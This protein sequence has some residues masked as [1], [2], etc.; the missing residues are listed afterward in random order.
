MGEGDGSF[1]AYNSQTGERLWH[2]KSAFGVNAPPITYTVNGV[3][4]VAV[5]SG[6]SS[7]FGYKQGDAIL[8]YKLAQ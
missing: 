1:N 5:A 8:V 7:I 4:Y 6:G 2:A 3:Q